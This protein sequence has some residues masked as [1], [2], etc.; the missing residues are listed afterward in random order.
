MS[1]LPFEGL[2]EEV[3]AAEAADISSVETDMAGLQSH[4]A[5]DVAL[6]DDVIGR[7][8]QLE[9][10]LVERTNDVQRVQAEYANYRKRVDRDRE[11]VRDQAVAAALG[12]LL[13]VLDDIDRAAEHGELVGGFRSVADGL[14]AAV[15]KLG[16]ER[17][18]EAGDAFDPAIH[19][20]MTHSFS[21]EVEQTTCR[22]VF[23]PGYRHADRVIR[24]ARVAVVEPGQAD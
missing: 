9:R 24:P 23:Q 21:E 13:T 6:A 20:A 15:T 4:L 2:A 11:L 18:G 8:E 19:E 12:E 1:D 5:D 17:Y 14:L 16:L 22:Q 3:L 7:V 10:D